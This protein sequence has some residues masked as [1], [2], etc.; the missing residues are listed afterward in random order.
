[1]RG[2][3]NDNWIGRNGD[4]VRNYLCL[5]GFE[6]HLQHKAINDGHPIRHHSE[7]NTKTSLLSQKFS[8]F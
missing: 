8:I 1:M 2:I 7:C 6:C 5:F 3:W 4:E